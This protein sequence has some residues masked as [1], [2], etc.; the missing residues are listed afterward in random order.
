[1][2]TSV[3][4][5]TFGTDPEGFFEKDGKI[6]GSERV[7]PE[8]GLKEGQYYNSDVV[9][10][11]VQFELNPKSSNAIV[12]LG[13]NIGK[14]MSKLSNRLRG[15]PGVSCNWSGMVE[16]DRE[17]LDALSER[18]RILGCQP[19]LNRY[20]DR[21]IEVDVK[22]Y[23]K[24]SAGGH[25]H[26]GLSAPI[27]PSTTLKDPRHDLVPYLDIFVGN[28]GVLLDRDPNAAERREN[29][30][31]AGEYR[32]PKHGLEYRTTSN[33]WLRNYS[34][35]SFVFGM[36]HLAVSILHQDVKNGSNE[37]EKEL[38]DC[39]NIDNVIKAIDTNNYELARTNFND[40]RPFLVRHL[41]EKLPFPLYPEN[42]DNFLMFTE[43]V[44]ANGL[45]SF[46]PEDILK[47]WC[48]FKYV[49]FRDFLTKL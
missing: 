20:A 41:S 1:M 44:N 7:I 3:P 14:A 33:F 8:E 45:E 12:G 5:I 49:S 48:S 13:S 31:R 28:T 34:I 47:H 42:I 35:M 6:I 37:L 16:V 30:G 10:D 2:I 11:G 38:I 4:Y 40:I 17:E 36:A 25:I 19:S 32:L 46:F 23:R 21:P 26:L 43:S 39:V 29:Y 18:S 27:F 22:A 15:C 9:R 24:R